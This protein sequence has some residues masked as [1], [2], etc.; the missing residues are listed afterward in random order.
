[1]SAKVVTN[2]HIEEGKVGEL[3]RTVGVDYKARIIDPAIQEAVKQTTA[4]YPVGEM[5]TKRAAI[6]EQTLKAIKDRLAFRGVIVEDISF[7]DINFSPA[8]TAA[9]EQKQVAEQEAQKAA[10]LA[11]KARNEAQ[12]EIA[13]AQGQSEAQRLLRET[14]NDQTIALRTLEVQKDAIAKWNGVMPTYNGTGNLLFNIP[15]R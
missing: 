5:I 4:K 8:F 1:V 2:Y 12:A 7:T 14:A 15:Q 13:K 10:Y 11:E 6:K 3:Y 9:I